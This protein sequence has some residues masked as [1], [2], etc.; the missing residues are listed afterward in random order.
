MNEN[1][2]E[3]YIQFN[4]EKEKIVFNT[5]KN[6]LLSKCVEKFS[7]FE[8][9]RNVR[10]K[11]NP[12]DDAIIYL[13]KYYDPLKAA[14]EFKKTGKKPEIVNLC[15]W[16]LKNKKLTELKDTNITPKQKWKNIHEMYYRQASFKI[17]IDLKNKC[18][19]FS[20]I[21]GPLY[22]R[23]YVFD[24]CSAGDDVYYLGQMRTIW[25]S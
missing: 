25:N 3:K 17:K 2:I 21:I 6:I 4:T 8:E 19:Y 24:I 23:G 10:R 20:E 13:Q 11:E 16:H 5:I 22:G 14:I 12:P 9:E 18:V 15:A 7:F 1:G